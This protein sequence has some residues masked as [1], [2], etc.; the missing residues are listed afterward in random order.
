ME[1]V[2]ALQVFKS[3]HLVCWCVSMQTHASLFV[4]DSCME[5]KEHSVSLVYLG[6]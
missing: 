6:S 2:S 4:I 5:D 3:A 1:E